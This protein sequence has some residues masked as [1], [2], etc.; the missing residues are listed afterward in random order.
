MEKIA[1]LDYGSQLTHLLATE[2]RRLG[3]Y[4]EI[5]E[6]EVAASEL[7]E[8]KGIILSG[9]PNSV[10]DPESPQVDDEVFNLGIP[11]LGIC[12]GHQLMTHKLGGKVETADI[13]EYGK[14]DI[15]VVDNHGL[16]AGFEIGEETQVWM[17][18]RDSITELPEGFQAYASSEDCEYAVIGDPSRNFYSIQFHL[19]VVHTV[20]GREMLKNFLNVCSVSFDWNL[21][22]FLEEKTKQIQAE[23][24]DQ[25]VFLLVSGGVD[26]TVAFAL[27]EKALGKERVY[28]MFVDTGFMRQ[29][30]V[31]EVSG[32]LRGIGIDD[33]H[34]YSGAEEYF[35]ALEGKFEPESKRKTIGDLFLDI[36]AKV[37]DHLNLNPDEWLLG[38][39]TIYPDTIESGGTKHADKI[40]THH[41]R[42]QRI[43]DLM[44]QGKII[45]PIKDLYKDEVRKLGQ[46]LG[47]PDEMVQRHPF[48]GPGL[49]VRILCTHDSIEPDNSELEAINEYLS[50]HGLSGEILPIKSVGVQGDGRTY[51]YPLAVHGEWP[52]YEKL[53]EVSTAL[54]NKF[55][56]INRVIFQFKP[57]EST[58]FETVTSQY[59]TPERTELLQKADAIFTKILKE[60]GHYEKIWQSP[61]VLLPVH[62][63][64][65]PGES[66]V[67]R[68]ISSREAMTADVYPLPIE[69]VQQFIQEVEAQ[70]LPISAIFYDL[71]NKP[72]GTIE[73]E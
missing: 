33:L 66:I 38:Q 23:A 7:K 53:A 12:Y 49:A 56:T 65:S 10:Y 6:P 4:S 55:R 27:L 50:N 63:A 1:I 69:L 18:H 57:K 15:K 26:S 32:A 44:E 48:P 52:G 25:K 24:G 31:E 72:P 35:T 73:W 20:K 30:E 5:L 71:T 17:S 43:Q 13:G 70:N 3:V 22:D 39:G 47:L 40:K 61:V 41:N 16:L 42:V 64:H 34:V 9:G 28:G 67:L 37:S 51:R 45:E 59:L 14:A 62:E 58:D 21:E 29:N 60:S 46:L 54:T 8:Y 2:V 68:P 19:E 11:V 36:Q